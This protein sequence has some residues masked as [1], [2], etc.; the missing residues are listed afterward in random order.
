METKCTRHIVR[1]FAVPLIVML[2]A[3]SC[4]VANERIA[5]P[6]L[7]ADLPPTSNAVEDLEPLPT[8]TTTTSAAD[9]P[10]ISEVI[11]ISPEDDAS[12]IVDEAPEGT[13]F[14]FLPGVHRRFSVGPKDGMTFVGRE[15]AILSGAILLGDAVETEDGWRF[16]GIEFTGAESGS[17][18]RGYDGCRLSQDL[19]FDD[20]MMWQVTDAANLD[21]GTWYREGSSI[22]VVDDPSN[23][24][25]ELSIDEHAFLGASSDVTIADLVVEKYATP[26]QSGAIQAQDPGDGARGF[27]WLIEDV[28]VRGVHGAGI[29]AGDQTIMRRVYVHH[30]GQLGIA[31][32]GGTDVLLEDSEI[33]F[34]NVAGFSSGWE[35]GGTKSARTSGLVVRGNYV[36]DN[37]GP[38]LWTDIDNVDTLYESNRVIDNAGAGIFHEISYSAVIR[39]NYVEGNGFGKSD[40]LWGAGILIAASSDVEVVDNV[41]VDN[42]NGI[43]GIQQDRGSGNLGDYLLARL[44]VHENSIQLGNGLVGIVEDVGDESVFRDRDNR[45]EANTYIGR[46][47]FNYVW[48]GRRMDKTDWVAAGQDTEGIWR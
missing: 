42:A 27:G 18:I 38:G 5:S 40:W 39:D 46:T 12:Q 26:A 43:G 11:T 9:G 23:R 2:V 28:E 4:T 10:E 20:V 14:E 24:G 8:D 44:N 22:Y 37:I 1:G 36:H 29:R 17:C 33:A 30:N 34:N 19:F 3:T 7:A 48:N 13:T 35:A 16:D 15:G 41:L 45:F 25:V 21:V 47:G 31:I 6:P 32:S